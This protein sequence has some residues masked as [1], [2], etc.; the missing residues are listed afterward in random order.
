MLGWR[1]SAQMPLSL[2]LEL[3]M[4]SA[5]NNRIGVAMSVVKRRNNKNRYMHFQF[6]GQTYSIEVLGTFD[7]GP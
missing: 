4:V 1:V 6:N 2:M 7:Y 5:S 3:M